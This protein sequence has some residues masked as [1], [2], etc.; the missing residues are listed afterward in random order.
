MTDYPTP[1]AASTGWRPSVARTAIGAIANDYTPRPWSRRR[2]ICLSANAVASGSGTA[3]VSV[4][5]LSNNYHGFFSALVVQNV[6]PANAADITVTYSNDTSPPSRGWQ[7]NSLTCSSPERGPTDRVPGLRYGNDDVTG[8]DSCWRGW[9]SRNAGNRFAASVFR[10]ITRS[11]TWWTHVLAPAWSSITSGTPLS[12]AIQH[13]SA[14]T[15]S[16][17]G[18]LTL[19]WRLGPRRYECRASTPR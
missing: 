9:I 14:S 18:G 13:R 1:S 2:L 8:L 16:R 6:D 5:S 3:T 15:R 10:Y 19:T 12:L 11:T 17:I 7:S 4:P